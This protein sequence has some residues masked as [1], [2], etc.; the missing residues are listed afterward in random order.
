VAARIVWQRPRGTRARLFARLERVAED[1]PDL[2]QPK[3]RLRA[4][5]AL[6]S[7]GIPHV[8]GAATPREDAIGLLHLA[9]EVEHALMT[10][11]LYAALS[12]TGGARSAISR[13]AIQEMGHLLTVQ[14]LLL[15]LN[16]VSDE[17][18]PLGLHLGRDTIRAASD[19]NPLPFVLEPVSRKALAK[20]VVVERPF[21]LP[22]ATLDQRVAQLEL[23]MAS[24]GIEPHPVYAL[25]AAIRWIFQAD[26]AGD[27]MGLTQELGFEP[28]WHLAPED[29]VDPAIGARFGSDVTEWHS[30]PG[31]I[32]AVS[33]D[34]GQA[35]DALDAIAAQGEGLP[36]GPDSHFST[37]ITLLDRMEAGALNPRPL[38]RTPIIAAQPAPEDPTPT[39]ITNDY[40]ILWAELFNLVYELLLVDI[41][42]AIS[43]PRGQAARQ[44]CIDLAIEMMERAIRPL[45]AHIAALPLGV[46][47]A[48]KA[49]PPYGLARQDFPKSRAA[50]SALFTQCLDRQGQLHAALRARPEFAN[51]SNADARLAAI[52]EIAVRRAPYLPEGE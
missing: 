45:S 10:Q 30:I 32:I 38:P 42:W 44:A 39:P 49:A 13:I 16:G 46:D 3:L 43:Q 48:D 15:G 25:Y 21:E 4:A 35:L 12:V 52:E 20:F 14:N 31:L 23:E 47:P 1:L 41:A 19:R 27:A 34:R 26:D 50:F 5:R 17:D 24:E 7:A 9:A 22:D 29:F 18:L 51:N 36:G 11:Y 40:T 28:G 8:E 37:F 6:F 2:P 33:G